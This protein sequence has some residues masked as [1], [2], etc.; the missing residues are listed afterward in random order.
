[1]KTLIAIAFPE[2]FRKQKVSQKF[3]LHG[4]KNLNFF[5]AAETNRSVATDEFKFKFKTRSGRNCC[6]IVADENKNGFRGRY[7]KW[8]WIPP[9]TEDDAADVDWIAIDYACLWSLLSIA[10]WV[11]KLIGWWEVWKMHFL[12][13]FRSKI[14]FPLRCNRLS[15]KQHSK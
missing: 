14:K 6:S 13:S 2:T 3:F 1:M 7:G 4:E 5:H 8:K 9:S 11:V 10:T 12:I 15:G